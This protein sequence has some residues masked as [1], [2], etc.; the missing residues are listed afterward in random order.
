MRS[1]I[2]NLEILVDSDESERYEKRS[3]SCATR[4]T[5]FLC[6]IL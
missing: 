4:W 3:A 1:V 2:D 6:E 5:S